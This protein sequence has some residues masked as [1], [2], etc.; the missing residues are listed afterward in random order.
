MQAV[1]LTQKAVGVLVDVNYTTF[2][3]HPIIFQPIT[4]LR[5]AHP[6]PDGYIGVQMS[7]VMGHAVR[8]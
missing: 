4:R 1:W 7:Q 5:K 6:A 8:G 2:E 3:F